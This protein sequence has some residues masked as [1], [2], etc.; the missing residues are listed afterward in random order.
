MTIREAVAADHEA[1]VALSLRAW[2]PV[3]TSVNAVLGDELATRLHGEDW[4]EHQ[5]RAVRDTL[6]GQG[7][8]GWVTEADGRITG[9]AVASIA[10]LDRRVGEIA[11]L[12]VDPDAQGHGIGRALTDH[13]TAWLREAG[14]RVAVIG[15][16]GD[17]GHAP[18]RAVYEQA[19]YRALP[20]VQYF[21][22]L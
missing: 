9:F 15:T 21:K 12:A 5:T 14:M 6:A 19:G 13:A 18:A 10:D 8:H 1:I 7:N 20:G 22:A 3:F 2:A 16:G 4:R 17:P 11:M